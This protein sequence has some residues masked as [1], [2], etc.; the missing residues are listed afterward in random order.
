M[1]NKGPRVKVKLVS[2]GKNKAGKKTGYYKTTYRNTR[3]T[4]EKLV[5]KKYDPR[6]W[7][8]THGKLGMIVEFK[9]EKIK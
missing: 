3:N 2:T 6:A 9:E 4:T 5:L 7:D 8:V 1:A